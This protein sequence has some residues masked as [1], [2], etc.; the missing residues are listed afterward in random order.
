MSRSKQSSERAERRARLKAE[1]RAV[2]HLEKFSPHIAFATALLA[3]AFLAKKWSEEHSKMM[4]RGDTREVFRISAD[5]FERIREARK[6]IPADV[7]VDLI[8]MERVLAL[9]TGFPPDVMW[10]AASTVACRL[11]IRVLGRRQK[12][13][14]FAPDFCT[15]A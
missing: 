12:F 11:G 13:S 8:A 2:A 1:D 3:E 10:K 15:S 4:Q 14:D 7:D 5:D 9:L 6:F